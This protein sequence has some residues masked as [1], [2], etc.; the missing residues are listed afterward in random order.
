MGLLAR[1][2]WRLGRPV[3]DPAGR[4]PY[5]WVEEDGTTRELTPDEQAYLRTEFHPADGGRPY[6]KTRCRERTAGGRLAGFL[7]R[8]FVPDNAPVRVPS[9]PAERA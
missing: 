5:V 4:F 6:V 8:V 2:A 7:P 3:P 9:P 1:I